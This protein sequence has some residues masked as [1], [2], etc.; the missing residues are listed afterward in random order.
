MNSKEIVLR[1]IERRN[2]PRLPIHYC[3]RD[4][5]YSDTLNVGLATRAGFTPSMPG[6][7][8]WGYAWKTLDD[9]MGQPDIR[10][11]A[12]PS[13]IATYQP[14]DAYAPGRF[15]GLDA[16]IA[17]H[18]DRFIKFGLGI[19]G[20]NVATFLRGF[21][22]LLMDLYLEPQQAERVVDMVFDYEMGLIEQAV[23]HPIDAV[24][25]GDD[26]GT[27]KGLMI[28]PELWRKVFKPRYSA[29]FARVHQGGKK[30]W[31]HTCGDV[32]AI[33]PDLIEVGADVLELLQPDI[34]GVE[35]LAKAFGGQVCFCCS[36]D[37]QRRAI[38]GTRDEIFAYA[39]LLRDTLGAFNG[40]YIAYI[41]DY[42]SLGMSEQNYQW[43]REA[44]H[45]LSKL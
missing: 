30:V 4:F 42:A 17:Q 39:R 38:S 29:Q 44:F 26:W 33:I 22:E 11:L 9:T 19:T 23:Q 7:T 16:A 32:W 15:D 20:F 25:F 28:Q 43:I 37:H 24:T 10:P 18:P 12:D 34:F 36:V 45:S 8:E 40:G 13:S 2:P 41:E 35:R 3:N 27:Q 1:A 5:E 6:M 14:P 31:F 21:E